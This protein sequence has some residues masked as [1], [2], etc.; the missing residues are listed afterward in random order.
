MRLLCLASVGSHL[1]TLWRVEQALRRREADLELDIAGFGG[2]LQWTVADL[3]YEGEAERHNF[4]PAYCGLKD[5]TITPATWDVVLDSARRFVAERRPDLLLTMVD[6]TCEYALVKAARDLGVPTVL[7]Q[8]G[9]FCALRA[10]GPA[11]YQRGR[12]WARRVAGQIGLKPPLPCW[13]TV[14]GAGGADRVA[15]GSAFYADLFARKAGVDKARIVVTGIPRYDALFERRAQ[16]VASRASRRAS[17]APL[18]AMFM[19]QPL[20]EYGVARASGYARLCDTVARGLDHLADATGARITARLHPSN[21]PGDAQVFQKRMKHPCAEQGAGRHLLDVL[22]DFDIVAG[23]HSTGLLES[24]GLGI[25][26]V[27]VEVPADRKVMRCFSEFGLP[28]AATAEQFCVLLDEAAACDGPRDA[29]PGVTNEIGEIDGQ[30]SE[31]VADLCLGLVRM[32]AV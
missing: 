32:A 10:P 5:R 16:W 11:L 3:P 9:P 25:P 26:T 18:E 6:R 31:R 7:V 28:V 19:M 14:Y 20:V 29:P 8:E 17:G 15:A 21:K 24:V 30:A 23:F 27:S 22:P 1:Q 2:F 4:S 13:P 12:L